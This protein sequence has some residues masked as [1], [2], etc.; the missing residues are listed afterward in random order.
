MSSA[1]RRGDIAHM[2]FLSMMCT[3]KA[4]LLK[5]PPSMSP[6]V[7]WEAWVTLYLGHVNDSHTWHRTC[8]SQY[9]QFTRTQRGLAPRVCHWAWDRY[10]RPRQN[11]TPHTGTSVITLTT[12]VYDALTGCQ[13][14]VYVV[15]H[16]RCGDR[17]GLP[18]GISYITLLVYRLH[19]T[20]KG[21]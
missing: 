3:I 13:A 7:M 6:C 8:T 4:V 1:H 21:A 18:V 11:T 14:R 17:L 10:V 19:A 15:L 12:H 16:K 20:V 9:V 2:R 5:T